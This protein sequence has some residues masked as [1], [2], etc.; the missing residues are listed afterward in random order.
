[1]PEIIVYVKPR[2]LRP[3][4]RDPKPEPARRSYSAERRRLIRKATPPWAD[5]DAIAGLYAEA[6]K[7]TRRHRK[8]Y[9]VDHVLPLQG[10]NVCGLHVETNL[11]V[12][13][14]RENLM[15][16]NRIFHNGEFIPQLPLTE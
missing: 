13:R 4:N 9:H 11:R 2:P 1:M 16:R 15:K 5:R 6:R 12:V 10:L 8:P 7:L 3:A 14:S